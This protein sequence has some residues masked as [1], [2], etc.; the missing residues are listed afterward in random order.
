VDADGTKEVVASI[1][2]HNWKGRL[3]TIIWFY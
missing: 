2:T 1:A 3:Y